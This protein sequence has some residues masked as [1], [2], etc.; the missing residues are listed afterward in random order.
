MALL[1]CCDV[2]GDFE[3]AVAM[4]Y[5]RYSFNYTP[6]VED[7]SQP[8][9]LTGND[10]SDYTENTVIRIADRWDAQDSENS[11][12]TDVEPQS[13]ATNKLRVHVMT[14]VQALPS[15][16]A[17]YE[18]RV[19]RSIGAYADSQ[20]GF[21]ALKSDSP[22]SNTSN[23][24]GLGPGRLTTAH[25]AG[26]C[27]SLGDDYAPKTSPSG[28][29]GPRLRSFDCFSPGSPFIRD[30]VGMMRSN[31]RLRARYA[32]HVAEWLHILG[33]KT[34]DF[35]AKRSTYTYTLPH[36]SNM[37]N[38]YLERS[39]VNYPVA[40]DRDKTVGTH[41]KFDAFLYPL[42]QDRFSAS[43]LPNLTSTTDEFD[44]MICV[45]VKMKFDF[46]I[47]NST[48]IHNWLTQV[49]ARINQRF[50]FEYYVR[51]RFGNRDYNRCL[52]FFSPRYWV[53]DYSSKDPRD[54]SEHIEVD[55]NGSGSSEWDSSYELDFRHSH[56]PGSFATFFGNMIG[57]ADGTSTTTTHYN[58]IITG[59]MPGGSVRTL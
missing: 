38:S 59:V 6:A 8:S 56:S 57:L 26:H 1:R 15:S 39:H 24:D 53:D 18:V 29:P 43:V 34:E 51:G 42:G 41:G 33:G 16:K 31:R 4:H 27:I 12:P 23:T 46:D 17:H 50:N 58:P 54:T 7:G 28:M 22:A 45:I 35:V 14:F 30:D 37:G 11:H 48:D 40:S 3:I 44:G 52:L 25:E 47:T 20:N 2:D 5:L 19:F 55:V 21:V 13:T 10:A 36:H 9:G 32:W 49:D